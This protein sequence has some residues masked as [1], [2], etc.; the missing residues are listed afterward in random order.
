VRTLSLRRSLA[1]KVLAVAV[2]SVGVGGAAI[3]AG[4][5]L[6][7]P[8][9]A[10]PAASG[11]AH[12]TATEPSMIEDGESVDVDRRTTD[13]AHPSGFP[14]DRP[15][16]R[17]DPGHRDDHVRAIGLCRAWDEARKHDAGALTRSTR[18]QELATRAGGSAKVAQFCDRLTYSWCESHRWPA[19]QPVQID[20]KP[21]TMRC[22]RPTGRPTALPTDGRT[23]IPVPPTRPA[24]PGSGKSIPLPTG[25]PVRH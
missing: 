6:P 5:H 9:K 24:G 21:L 14:T 10:V 19:Y 7:G 3:A 1:L 22:I 20:G 8:L 12:P 18:F 11:T 2:A 17:E 16:P 25:G 23:H 15:G 13:K 4:G